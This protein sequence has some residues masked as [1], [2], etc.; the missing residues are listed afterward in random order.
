MHVVA[1]TSPLLNLVVIEQ[2]DLLQ[3]L[4][5]TIAAPEVVRSEIDSLSQRTRDFLR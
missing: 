3:K 4:F 1:N 5:G 2:V